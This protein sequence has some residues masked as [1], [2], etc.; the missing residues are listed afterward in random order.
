M[1]ECQYKYK[2]KDKYKDKDKGKDKDKDKYKVF[3]LT[4]SPWLS[5]RMIASKVILSKVE[6]DKD[7][8]LP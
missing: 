5:P 8:N 1:V 3:L 4:V 2:Y 6:C 7:A